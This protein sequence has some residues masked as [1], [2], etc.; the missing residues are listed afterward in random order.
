VLCYD[1]V[2]DIT[3]TIELTI[4]INVASRTLL[5][6]R[7]KPFGTKGADAGALIGTR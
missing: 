1:P 5:A 4:A 3:Y 7:F 2:E 6:W